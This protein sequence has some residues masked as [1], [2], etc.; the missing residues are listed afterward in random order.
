MGGCVY[1]H[2]ERVG[3]YRGYGAT[4]GMFAMESAVNE[5]AH[6]P[7]MGS[8][9]LRPQHRPGQARSRRRHYGERGGQLAAGWMPCPG[10][11]DDG[12]KEKYPAK[13]L[14]NGHV[15]AVGMA[16]AMQGSGI[17]AVDT[18][19]L[20]IGPATKE[21]MWDG[22][23]RARYGDGY[24]TILAQI[25]AEEA[26]TARLAHHRW[27]GVDTDHSPYDCGS[28]MRPAQPYVT[29]MAVIKTCEKLIRQ[30]E[31]R[32]A[33]LLAWDARRLFLK[34]TV[35]V[36][37]RAQGDA[38]ARLLGGADDLRRWIP[39]PPA[40]PTVLRSRRRRLW[41]LC[42]IDLTRRRAWSRWSITSRGGLRNGHQS[43]AG[44]RVQTEAASCRALAYR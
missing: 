39:S 30:L 27:H 34:A 14:P 21:P 37:R 2:D 15:R 31:R 7:N 12:W 42:G 26:S 5:L 41:R 44:A 22:D 25:A 8:R 4:Q 29:G 38:S 24:D 35:C 11:G 28:V 36:V 43:S 19:R 1:Q 40:R 6:R 10:A 13:T 3:A 17:S 33:K 20:E 9:R 32:D 16:L 18:G 23:W